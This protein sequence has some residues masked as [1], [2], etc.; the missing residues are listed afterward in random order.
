MNT[1]S[2][3]PGVVVYLPSRP[4]STHDSQ[5][6][7]ERGPDRGP[8]AKRAWGTAGCR[9]TGLGGV[10]QNLPFDQGLFT[11][12]HDQPTFRYCAGFGAYQPSMRRPPA[13]SSATWLVLTFVRQ[14]IKPVMEYSRPNFSFR[15]LT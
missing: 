7:T 6:P 14:A 3:P 13:T 8:W 12:G 15:L 2:R 9:C 5:D 11:I 10:P 4:L 1:Y